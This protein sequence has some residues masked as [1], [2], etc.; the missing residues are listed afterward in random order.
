MF[1]INL[2]AK[3]KEKLQ[4][5]EIDQERHRKKNS[6]DHSDDI[7]REMDIESLKSHYV[8]ANKDFEMLRTMLNSYTYGD[9]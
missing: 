6:E 5:N 7:F 9:G 3:T 4:E 1:I 2:K 8:R